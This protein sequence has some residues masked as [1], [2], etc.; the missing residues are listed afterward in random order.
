MVMDKLKSN[1][2]LFAVEICKSH[3]HDRSCL[4]FASFTD[5]KLKIDT[6]KVS[7]TNIENYFYLDAQV[8]NIIQLYGSA[9]AAFGAHATEWKDHYKGTCL[10]SNSNDHVNHPTFDTTVAM[11]KDHSMLLVMAKY[12]QD[13][14]STS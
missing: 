3:V 5:D 6:K 4:I 12:S 1:G 7:P 13:I 2:D 10:S 9:I 14:G 11:G 8:Q